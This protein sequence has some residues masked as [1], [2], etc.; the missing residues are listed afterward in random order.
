MYEI[1]LDLTVFNNCKSKFE[2]RLGC[3]V[4]NTKQT[5]LE[6]KET[7]QTLLSVTSIIYTV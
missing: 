4:L 5:F 7:K 2:V 1:S 3:F 6:K